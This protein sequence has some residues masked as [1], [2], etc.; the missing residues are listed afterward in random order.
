MKGA[1]TIRVGKRT[2]PI[3]NR[4]K[5]LFP[6]DGT[7]KGDL[8]D[9]YVAIA[10]MMLPY[11]RARP[12]T[13]ERYPDGIDRGRVFQKNISKYFPDWIPRETV[14]KK[15][16]AVTHVLANDQATLA[17][18]ANQACVTHHVWLSTLR[19]PDR[20]DQ[21]I[22]DLDPSTED[23]HE[24]REVALGLRRVLEGLDLTPF[25]KTSGSRGLHIVVPLRPT[26]DFGAV[27]EFATAIAAQMI[28]ADPKRLTTEFH[29]AKRGNKIY[30]DI[31]RNA[32]AQTAV[33]PYTVRARPGAPVAAPVTWDEVE[34]RKLKPTAFSMRDVLKRVEEIQDPWKG[35]R[36]AATS[37][38]RA[39]KAVARA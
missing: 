38:A 18:L 25:V 20:P 13:L 3:S 30:F 31:G 28:E 2:I 37:I 1:E 33:A 34:D 17:Y 7:T 19:A 16:G 9:Y 5:V 12:L 26:H 11:T 29:K 8:I 4:D 14:G 15:G 39:A 35:F 6:Q 27:Y 22:F 10:P 36:D 21:L 23:F 32:Y 24:V